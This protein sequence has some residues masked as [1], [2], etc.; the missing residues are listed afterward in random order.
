MALVL[1]L[2]GALLMAGPVCRGWFGWPDRASPLSLRLGFALVVLSFL[3]AC[4]PVPICDNPEDPDD[5]RVEWVSG[6]ELSEGLQDVQR[7]R[8]PK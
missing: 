8:T 3:S 4:V 1:L 2:I 7:R 5:C 6:S